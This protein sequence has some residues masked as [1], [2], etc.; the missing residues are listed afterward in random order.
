MDRGSP[1]L[2]SVV[3]I[4]SNI[5]IHGKISQ[6]DGATVISRIHE[7]EFPISEF[8]IFM[9]LRN[10]RAL[11][12]N[13]CKIHVENECISVRIIEDVVNFRHANLEL[14]SFLVDVM[15]STTDFA[16]H[17]LDKAERIC[18]LFAALLSNI[19]MRTILVDTCG[20]STRMEEA[21][22]EEVAVMGKF[23]RYEP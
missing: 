22:V 7:R 20:Y 11:E 1:L 12:A 23:Q 19:G 13:K 6:A 18:N 10:T 17:T 16:Q 2:E 14:G 5:V 4:T 15:V 3:L 21:E 8:K 9:P